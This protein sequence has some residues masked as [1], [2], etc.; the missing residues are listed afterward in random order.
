MAARS[1][2]IFRKM[3][4]EVGD[5]LL[6]LG[7]VK[8][9]NLFRLVSSGNAALIAFR[10]ST[11]NTE[12]R[13][14]FTID[15]AIVCGLLLESGDKGVARA[16]V[17]DAHLRQRIGTFLPDKRDKWWEIND[18][19]DEHFLVTEISALVCNTA[20]PYVIRC[21]ETKE[22]LAIWNSGLAPG[23]TEGMR[24]K[25]LGKLQNSLA[26]GSV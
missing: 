14:A 17:M 22:L 23:I 13:L 6:P 3:I 4:S 8:S 24:I 16:R 9:G 18:T 11:S 1:D 15:L 26:E 2:T 20:V 7:F 12:E 19:T 5:R 10:R 21:L 25:Y